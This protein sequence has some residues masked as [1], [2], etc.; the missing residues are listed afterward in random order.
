MAHPNHLRFLR[1]AAFAGF[2]V[3][4]AAGSAAAQAPAAP[5]QPDRSL[6]LVSPVGGF[7]LMAIATMALIGVSLLP[8][9]RG[10]QD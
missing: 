5:P 10:H 7:A 2:A 8:S 1:L 3:L 6:G 4:A 9:K